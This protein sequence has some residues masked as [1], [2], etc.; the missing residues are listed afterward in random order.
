[1]T[2]SRSHSK[3]RLGLESPVSQPLLFSSH[4]AQYDILTEVNSDGAKPTFL[5]HAQTLRK[6]EAKSSKF[7]WQRLAH[8][9]PG[10]P[11][12]PGGGI[13]SMLGLTPEGPANGNNNN[14]LIII[15]A[16]TTVL[17]VSAY[18]G[19]YATCPL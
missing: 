14:I 8:R 15:K 19:A 1:M 18:T 12:P 10:S 4:A 9:T 11:A 2:H 7:C 17:V 5:E 13:Y 6:P 3:S 16:A